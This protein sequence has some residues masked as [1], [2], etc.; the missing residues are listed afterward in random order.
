MRAITYWLNWLSLLRFL[1]LQIV[2][3]RRGS[4][5]RHRVEHA[6]TGLKVSCPAAVWR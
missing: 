6:T 4:F 3:V 5:V 1:Y 2:Q